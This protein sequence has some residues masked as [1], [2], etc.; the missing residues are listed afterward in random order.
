MFKSVMIEGTPNAE[1]KA[2]FDCIWLRGAH[3]WWCKN[4]EVK[5]EGKYYT[6][7]TI[8]GQRLG[9]PFWGP[10]KVLPPEPK[11][12]FKRFLNKFKP[13]INLEDVVYIKQK[14][15]DYEVKND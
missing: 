8:Y 4:P 2:C 5:K 15:F 3:T 7:I 10:C 13:T 6:N 14:T 9:C 12:K 1:R 11:S